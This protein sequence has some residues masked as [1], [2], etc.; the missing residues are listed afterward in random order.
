ME[1]VTYYILGGYKI[2]ADGIKSY[3]IKKTLAPWKESYNK[4]RQHIQKQTH[5]FVNK[6]P[7]SQR[8][9]FSNSHVWM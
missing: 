6:G 4:P 5:H 9:G 3:G 7:S 1:A 8:Y 2:P